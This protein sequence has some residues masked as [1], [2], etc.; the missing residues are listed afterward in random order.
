LV[1]TA[2]CCYVEKLFRTPA[3]FPVSPFLDR[4]QISSIRRTIKADKRDKTG[5]GLVA[6]V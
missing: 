2:F 1:G 3:Q 5:A 4:N 6:A